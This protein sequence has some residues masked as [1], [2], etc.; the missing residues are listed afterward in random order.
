MTI[1]STCRIF[2]IGLTFLLLMISVITGA[3]ALLTPQW[4]TVYI[5]EFHNEHY[6]GLW[7]DC[8]IGKKHVQGNLL[9][10]VYSHVV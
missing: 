9:F 10:S 8:I 7:L 1:L 2:A 5:Y 3:I 6:H 4:Q